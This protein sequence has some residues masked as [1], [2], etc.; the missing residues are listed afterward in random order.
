MQSDKRLLIGIDGLSRSGKTTLVGY[1]KRNLVL[2]RDIVI[3]HID[4][5]IVESNK[6]YN[7][8]YEQW[9]EYYELQWEV[10]KLREQLFEKVLTKNTYVLS[11]PFYDTIDDKRTFKEIDLKENSIVFL[12]GI[13]LQRKEWRQFF[14]YIV[15]LDCSREERF[16]REGKTIKAN[17]SKFED[18][19]W[20][21]EDYY[22]DI[23]N[24]KVQADIVING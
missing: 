6:R 13:F 9:Y 24:P 16:R 7:T 17:L 3:L 20:K 8:D 14:D 23:I 11:L 18:R 5:F 19:Y 4:D 12:E 10:D 2:N 15:Y 22:L 1:L 21:A